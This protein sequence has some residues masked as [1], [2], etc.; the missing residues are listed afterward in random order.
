MIHIL[1][2][3][4]AGGDGH[5]EVVIDHSPFV[6]GRHPDC[7]RAVGDPLVSRRHCR[8]F[9]LGDQVWVQDLGSLNGTYV[10]NV[11]L[12]GLQVL[13]DGDQPGLLDS[14]N[15]RLA[16]LWLQVL[17]DGDQ[18]RLGSLTFRVTVDSLEAACT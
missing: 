10:N 8:F 15:T 9:L 13:H 11:R 1:L 4:D 7:D 14:V 17:H 16:F 2:Q 3:P 5:A 18:L 6:V 12:P